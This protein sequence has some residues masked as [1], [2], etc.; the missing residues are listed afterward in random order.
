M[1][2]AGYGPVF[3]AAQISG[4]VIQL[5]TAAGGAGLITAISQA[6]LNMRSQNQNARE[7]VETRTERLQKRIDELEDQM[8]LKQDELAGYRRQLRSAEISIEAQSS[9]IAV[10]ERNLKL[11]EEEI[12]SLRRRL[13]SEGGS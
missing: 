12:K 5:L 3:V 4:P 6:I 8:V 11:Q 7:A 13:R 2:L 9:I 1:F 10:N